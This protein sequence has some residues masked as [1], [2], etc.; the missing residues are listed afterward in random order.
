M[1]WPDAVAG[2]R[3]G[4]F[5]AVSPA[6]S[7]P[8]HQLSGISS[9]ASAQRHQLSGISSAASAQRHPLSTG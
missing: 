1:P 2:C 9:A 5:S 8:R 3:G 4:D 6:L 7:A